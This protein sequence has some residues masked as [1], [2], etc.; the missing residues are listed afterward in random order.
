[1]RMTAAGN[2]DLHGQWGHSEQEL[3]RAL[4]VA[5]RYLNRRERT[6][7][8]TRQHLRK[9][10][11]G[12]PVAEQAIAVLHEQGVLDDVRFTR[13][14]VEDKRA[15]EQWGNERIRRT[16]LGRGLARDLV[17]AALAERDDSADEL[18]RAIDLLRTRFPSPPQERR[19]RDRALGMMLRKGYDGETAVDALAAYAR[20]R[21]LT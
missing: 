11:L 19:E 17:E 6:E 18:S 14:F 20:E 16:L 4:E 10:G 8:E 15:L 1:M 9:T 2:E 21:A 13:L 3:E 7:A 12:D 5:Y